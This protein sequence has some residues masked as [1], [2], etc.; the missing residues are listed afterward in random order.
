[1]RKAYEMSIKIL[2]IIKNGLAHSWHG[3]KVFYKEIKDYFKNKFARKREEEKELDQYSKSVKMLKT[4]QD[5]LKMLPFS[6][7]LI[8]PFA[9]LGLPLYLLLFP[10]SIPS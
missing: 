7:F 8:V 5:G 10:N 3:S 6:F 4:S 1:M 2:L 9:E